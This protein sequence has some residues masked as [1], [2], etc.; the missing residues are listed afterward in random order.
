LSEEST[1]NV[2]QGPTF[3]AWLL[4]ILVDIYDRLDRAES[5]LHDL[6]NKTN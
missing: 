6:E 4:P 2:T 1:K 5:R 3:I